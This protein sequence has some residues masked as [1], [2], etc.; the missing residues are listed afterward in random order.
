MNRK[1]IVIVA[2]L[3]SLVLISTGAAAGILIANSGDDSVEGETRQ[4]NRAAD[5]EAGSGKGYLGLTVSLGTPGTGLR[6]ATIESDGPADQAG[7]NVG[8]VIRAVDDS[9]VR[10]PERLRSVVEGKKPG[11]KVTLTYERG[12]R[13]RQTA[14]TLG[15]APADV[16]IESVPGAPFSNLLVNRVRLGV[17]IEQIDAATRTRLGLQ[18]DEGV[19]VVEVT[20]GSA[21]ERAGL[22]AN[23]IF[24]SING[25]SI[26][27]VDELQRTITA[28]PSNRPAE[29]RVLR[30][31]QQITL[32]TNLAPLL[33]I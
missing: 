19:V 12:D 10:T 17:R 4:V 23:D 14:L 8:D 31:E 27:T 13:L 30:G 9:V 24:V 26:D 2:L 1:F 7:L 32:S 18:R 15:N 33:S 6:V 16:E 25:T 22:Q 3:A 5:T 29:I 21:A 20:P 28:S 11:E